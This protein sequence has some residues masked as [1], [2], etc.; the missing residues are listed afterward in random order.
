MRKDMS[1]LVAVRSL[2]TSSWVRRLPTRGQM[3]S[4]E[5]MLAPRQ[6]T[7][8]STDHYTWMQVNKLGPVKLWLR[9]QAG[10]SWDAVY[11]ELCA[12]FNKKDGAQAYALTRALNQVEM[13]NLF[14]D[15]SGQAR[16]RSAY[17]G[18][19]GVDG[20]YVHP[21]TRVLCYQELERMSNARRRAQREAS[22][23]LTKV[24]VSPTLQLRELDGLWYWVELA[25]ITAPVYV[26][27]PDRVL[28][29]GT[30]LA[31]YPVL[32][33]SSVCRDIL[34]CREFMSDELPRYTRNE[35]QQDYGL[36]DHYARSK[37]Q[38]SHK[39]VCRYVPSQR[40]AA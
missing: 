12:A 25:R 6:S 26:Q 32:D 14:F 39:D 33:R 19:W 22:Q 35:L 31:G 11:S 13:H 9:Q 24:Q 20:L 7:R 15:E 10:R 37:R 1:R 34:T 18:D 29:D 27:T 30:V 23:P 17:G 2:Q 21:Q 5:E 4:N 8:A 3:P 36:P 38:A 16:V 40:L 28:S